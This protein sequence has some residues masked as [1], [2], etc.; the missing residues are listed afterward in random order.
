MA[1]QPRSHLFDP[2][3]PASCRE[4]G[5]LLLVALVAG[6]V[7]WARS[8]DRLPLR[9]DARVYE[10]ELAAP[11][12]TTGAAREF[13]DEGVRLF[14]DTRATTDGL[15]I[16]GALFIREDTFDDDLLANF[17]FIF[18]E[19]PLILFG[20]GDLTRTSNVAGRLR[21]RGYPNLQILAGGLAA[22]Q[23]GGGPVADT[24]EGTQP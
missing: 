23:Q 3:W 4:A 18:P 12:V 10:L 2:R 24:L 14:V 1:Y 22:W 16:P 15:T 19:D 6:G 20:D 8:P 11:L 17:D 13:Y 21:E 9:A 5:L 7:W